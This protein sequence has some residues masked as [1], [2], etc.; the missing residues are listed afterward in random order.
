MI[1]CKL[2]LVLDSE[3]RY[4]FFFFF[5]YRCSFQELSSSLKSFDLFPGAN[6]F[7]L[8]REAKSLAV[9]FLGIRC[10]KSDRGV[11]LCVSFLNWGDGGLSTLIPF[12]LRITEHAC[13]FCMIHIQESAGGGV[14]FQILVTQCEEGIAIFDHFQRVKCC[15]PEMIAFRW[16]VLSLD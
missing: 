14:D 1:L 3:L 4:Y 2:G 16:G 11:D 7:S 9:H 6:W 10:F 5:C 12:K 8:P 13:I 15:F